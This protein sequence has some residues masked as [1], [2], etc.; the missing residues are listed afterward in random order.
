MLRGHKVVTALLLGL[1][2]ISPAE[3]ACAA[4]RAVCA[5]LGGLVR[6]MRS[7]GDV[8]E[9]NFSNSDGPAEAFSACGPT[10]QAAAEAF[11]TAVTK[12]S[13]AHG[14]QHFPVWVAECLHSQGARDV[15][16]E[17]VKS[18]AWTPTV[19]R[20]DAN[21]RRGLHLAVLYKPRDGK[22]GPGPLDMYGT[23]ALVISR[24]HP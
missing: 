12:A 3:S 17:R 11:C 24:S 20:V 10:N 2:A 5:G 9:V 13:G 1:A 22:S 8:I 21:L 15:R 6:S 23:Y 19:D 18:E 14:L 16:I 4:P 7:S